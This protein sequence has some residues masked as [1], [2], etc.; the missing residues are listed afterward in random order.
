[1]SSETLLSTPPNSGVFKIP[2]WPG[3]AFLILSFLGFLDA[4]YLTAAH[5]F[6]VPLQCSILNGCELVTTSEYAV[7][8]GIPVAL[9]G[10]IYYGTIFLLSIAYAETRDIKFL[11]VASHLTIFGILA[12][13]W[14]VYLQIFVIKAICLYCILSAITST[15][16]FLLGMGVLYLLNKPESLQRS[17]N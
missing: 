13:A 4:S 1:M 15:L 14:F 9:A 7:V 16:L 8:F 10:A 12:S 2:A 5:Y 11:K 6:G 17:H 3:Y